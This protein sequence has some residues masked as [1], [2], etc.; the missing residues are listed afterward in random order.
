MAKK[1]QNSPETKS[2]SSKMTFSMGYFHASQNPTNDTFTQ[3]NYLSPKFGKEMLEDL[4]SQ[5][6]DLF[7]LAFS[8]TSVK[9]NVLTKAIGQIPT[10]F[11]QGS[12]FVV[13]SFVKSKFWRDMLFGANA[14][15]DLSHFLVA[16][17][18]TLQRM[19]D[20]SYVPQNEKEVVYLAEK[21]CAKEHIIQIDSQV[22]PKTPVLVDIK[23][24]FNTTLNFY[25]KSFSNL[26][27]TAFIILSILGMFLMTNMSKTAGISG[28][29]FTQYEYSKLT[30]NFYLDKIGQ[31]IPIDTN[32]LKGQKM[33]TLAA[34][35][36][37]EGVNTATLVDPEKVMH[38]YGSSFDTFT[39]ILAHFVGV[40]DYMNFRH[41]WNAI[42]GFFIM[43]Y[44]AL[45]VR[46]LTK[47]S[48]F[49]ACIGLV[50]LIL[51]PRLL[52][53]S[54][55]NPKDVPFALG[56]VM[57]LYY[58][59]K[60][61][62]NFPNFR[63]STVLGLVLGT[64]L[65][66]SI[67]IGGLLSIAIF[68]MHAGFKFIES[69][70]FDQFIKL[71]WNK[72]G[73]WFVWI[74]GLSLASYLFGIYFW[75][76]GWDQP[77]TNPFL[78]LKSFTNYAGSI[79]QLFEGK[80]YDSD[81]LPSYYL[82]KYVWITLPLVS[83]IGLALFVITSI[84]KRKE[85]T[86]EEFLMIFAAVFP[87]FY[88]FINHSQVYGG[89]RQI[90]FTI[91]CFVVVGV[92]GYAKLQKIIRLK[93]P[94]TAVL[95]LVI[96]LLPAKFIMANTTLSY[97]YFNEIVG[98][99][100]G[101]YGQYEMDYYLAGLR[102]SSEWFLENVA[103]KNPNKKF[104]VLTYGM[105]QVKY[106]CRNDKNVHVGYTRFDDRGSKMW[107]YAIFYNAYFDQGRLKSGEF[108]PKGTV[109]SP[110]VNGKPVGCVIQRPSMV[111]FEGIRAIE[112]EGNFRLGIEKLKE[113]ISI[114]PISS[115]SWFY[116]STAY[117]NMGN[118]DSAILC[119]KKSVESYPEYSKGLF[120]LHQFYMNQKKYDEAIKVMNQYLDARPADA[121]G[122]LMKA[123][124]LLAKQDDKTMETVNKAVELSPLDSRSYAIGA[125]YYQLKKDELN[126][127]QW[128][129]AYMLNQAK[130]QQ[131]QQA[132][133]ES[134]R[135]IYEGITGMSA[136]EF[137]AKFL[138]QQ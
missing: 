66:I 39:T 50:I 48:W 12:Y 5:D 19:F 26:S 122:Y 137:D 131:D 94:I 114:D 91:P 77:F 62:A 125:Q 45:I 11:K 41:F 78:A 46:R 8:A 118:L 83:L 119:A 43:F 51:T 75:P 10:S 65:G 129:Q 59:I 29:E 124:S 36:Q 98:N 22:A 95:A 57:S 121:E 112:K 71:R 18:E 69:I 35:Y 82:T 33:K 7:V 28:D 32:L 47:G 101:A 42:F 20:Q 53:E 56:Y 52:G 13:S 80:M 30:A 14:T 61:F 34:A 40:D 68:I 49:W 85:F 63:W 99:T 76:Y 74:L 120:A 73:K 127:K 103:R 9:S 96:S 38:L 97:I 67:R 88:I 116:M 21:S 64:A 70:G 117:A 135:I 27:K 109:F 15:H 100:E 60:L 72:F 126:F 115:E 55:N 23:N 130:S 2:T 81:M 16:D 92:V 86:L 4:I 113:Y 105:D 25:F 44:G 111:N 104:E 79:R 132:S 89:L 110:L 6:S 123:Q 93:F 134:I 138:Q 31:S 58:A 108:P 128:Y 106:Y 87:I 3:I 102:Q 1:T 24:K 54:L 37:N 136:D 17:K 90:L 84:I 133:L 107:D